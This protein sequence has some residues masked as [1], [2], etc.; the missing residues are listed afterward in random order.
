MNWS[1]V[2]DSVLVKPLLSPKAKTDDV[3]GDRLFVCSASS[4]GAGAV[5]EL[6]H[7]IE[8]QI[9]LLISLEELSGAGDIWILPDSTN[10]GVFMLTSDPISSTVLYLPANFDEE[11]SA[12]DEADCGLDLNAPTLAAGYMDSGSLIQVT[13]NAILVGGTAESRSNLR[14]DFDIGQSVTAAA[15]HG[16]ESLVVAAVRTHQD[17]LIHV[18]KLDIVGAHINLSNAVSPFAIDCEPICMLI[19][20]LPVGILIFIGTGDGRLLVYRLG[21][22]AQRLLDVA[23]TIEDDDDLSKAI[24]GLAI[25]TH[26]SKNNFR[27]A[28]LLC[29]LRSGFLVMFS[30]TMSI[31]R[32]ESP[33][34]MNSL[35]PLN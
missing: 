2:T 6:R 16:P 31:D 9:G 25:L 7:G 17:I 12:I 32:A 24:N 29:G 22:G 13:D 3:T 4:F 33:I 34:G 30:I 27:S 14:W 5:V 1:P 28:T 10:G 21:D 15:V 18:K 35:G 8:A 20:N 26:A 11:I 19:E 23:V